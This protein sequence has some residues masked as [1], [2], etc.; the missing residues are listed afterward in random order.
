MTSSGIPTSESQ[1]RRHQ[2]PTSPAHFFTQEQYQQIM[3]LLNKDKEAEPIANS[4]TAGT[5]GSIH[6]FMT[7]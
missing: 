6:A 4:V 1:G 7:S 2:T 5:T 3:H